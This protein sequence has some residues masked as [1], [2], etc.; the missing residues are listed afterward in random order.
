[1][2]KI[3]TL[4]VA[5]VATASMSFAS[6]ASYKIV[7]HG[8]DSIAV[9]GPAIN[10]AEFLTKPG[11]MEAGAEY[12]DSAEVSKVYRADHA[13][14]IKFNTTKAIGTL[15][16]TLSDMGKVKANKIVAEASAYVTDYKANRLNKFIINGVESATTIEKADT[17]DGKYVFPKYEFQLDGSE[18]SKIVVTTGNTQKARLNLKSL[19]VIFEATGVDAVETSK[20]VANVK[21]YNLTGVESAT[22]FEGVNVKVVTYTDG[23]KE[24]LKVVK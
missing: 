12:I 1:M 3:F 8:N 21:Y 7:F 5:L 10:S 16:L 22:P 15:T 9:D 13:M 18:L 19:E 20:E 4:I 23:T 17:V 24:A 11:V 14:G 2:K 6:S